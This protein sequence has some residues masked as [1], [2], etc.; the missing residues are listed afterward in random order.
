MVSDKFRQ[1]LRQEAAR[2]Q[3]D[4]LINAEQYQQ[5][6]QRYQ[7]ET[8]DTNA[9]DRFIVILISLG[10]ILLGLSAITFVAANWQAISRELKLLLLLLLLVGVNAAGFY[11]WR[12]P[13]LT[14]RR[15]WQQRLGQGLL[16]LGALILGANLALVG[17]LFHINGATAELC[18]IWG[19]AV[20]AMAY[21]LRLS[22]LG[23]LAIGLIGI[24][25][26]QGIQA[27]YGAGIAPGWQWVLQFMPLIAGALFV[28]L[29]YWCRSRLIFG[30]AAIAIIS[31]FE[32]VLSDVNRLFTGTSGIL[33]ALAVALPPALLW[34]YDDRLWHTAQ[35]TDATEHEST[36]PAVARRLALLVVTT[37]VYILSFHGAWEGSDRVPIATQITYLFTTGSPIL[38]N[39]NVLAVLG[40]TLAQWIALARPGRT[41][42]WRLSQTDSLMLLLLIAIALIVFW[43]WSIAPIMAIATLL[44]NLMLF[45]LAAQFLRQGL[46]DGKRY[47]FWSGMIILTIQILSRMLEYETGLLLK[48]LAFLVCGIGIM[49]IGLWFERHVRSLRREG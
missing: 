36:F 14:D 23:V 16:L 40:V 10:S 28:P 49:I 13:T 20:L 32:V 5:L 35:P 3:T 15:Q 22:S 27:S 19:L 11:L 12:H 7:F 25:Y 8:L 2:W 46:A 29:A 38:L 30:L 47:L 42:R 48:S 26:W 39:L 1:Q 4:G 21:S 41:G 18:L 33:V 31:S 45:L 44:F 37:L 43:H 6:S 9:R 34:S 24:G 17:Q